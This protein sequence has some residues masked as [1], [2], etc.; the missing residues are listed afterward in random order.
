MRAV[1]E[2]DRNSWSVDS[3]RN[4]QRPGDRREDRGRCGNRVSG[5][6]GNRW[7]QAHVPIIPPVVALGLVLACT[8]SALF[9]V[10]VA[11]QALDARRAPARH[12]LRPSLYGGLL[13][14]PRWVAGTLLAGAGWPFHLAALLVA[15]LTV[16][17]P[18]LASGLLLLL[19]LGHRIL[20]E[21]VGTRE[22]VAVS[23]IVAGVAGMAWAAPDRVTSHAHGARL[24][25][26]LGVLAAFAS[27]PTRCARVRAA[28]SPS[29]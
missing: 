19:V 24:Y 10:G 3:Q 28:A 15:P 20:G 6:G 25:V 22:V 29:R 11:I 12:A 18:A 23:A 5:C 27:R 7:G 9:A 17:Q 26:T 8:A 13:R 4:A 16:V 14:R 1:V 2:G 21:R